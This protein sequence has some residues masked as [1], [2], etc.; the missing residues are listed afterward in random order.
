LG[1]GYAVAGAKTNM[2]M[3][4]DILGVLGVNRRITETQ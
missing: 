1:G 3:D 4:N 2:S